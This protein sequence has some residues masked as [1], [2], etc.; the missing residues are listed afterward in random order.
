M[1]G[2]RVFSTVDIDLARLHGKTRF[3][4]LL[5]TPQYHVDGAL[6]SRARAHGAEIVYGTQVTGVRQDGAGT[7]VQA[8]AAGAGPVSYRTRY[9]VGADGGH[10]T[11]RAALGLAYPGRSVLTS[12]MLADVRLT[13]P[14]KQDLVVNTA[15][16][17]FVFVAPFGDG[18][19]RII[20]WGRRNQLPDD[21]P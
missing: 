5:N 3:P 16:A 2:L 13:D 10:S 11:V 21:A 18:W 19:F 6:L 8:Q 20:G 4:F 7:D 17:G 12:L 15:A 1:P 9:V 14:P